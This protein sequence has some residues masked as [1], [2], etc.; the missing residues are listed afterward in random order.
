[1]GTLL[2]EVYHSE[3]S[4]FCQI[5]QLLKV[6][7]YYVIYFFLDIILLPA[8]EDFVEVLQ[9]LQ[10]E[11][12]TQTQPICIPVSPEDDTIFETDEFFNLE[13][14]AIPPVDNSLSSQ[15]IASVTIINDDGKK[16]YAFHS[17][18]FSPN[19]LDHQV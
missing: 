5:K 18:I 6:Q 19:R 13:I 16:I 4:L 14:I 10:F 3:S 9:D 2:P 8:E 17:F 7:L 11:V 15:S 1:M 12:E